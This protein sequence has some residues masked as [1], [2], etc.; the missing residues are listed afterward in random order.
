MNHVIL[1][2]PSLDVSRRTPGNGKQQ[3][4]QRD[5]GSSGEP[6]QRS[7]VLGDD[8]GLVDLEDNEDSYEGQEPPERAVAVVV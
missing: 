8:D 2:P 5:G 6:H 3:V 7:I 1:S 4:R